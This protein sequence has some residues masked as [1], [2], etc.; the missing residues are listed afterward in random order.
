VKHFGVTFHEPTDGKLYA[1]GCKAVVRAQCGAQGALSMDGRGVTCRLCRDY[2]RRAR[3]L[4]RDAH[5]MSARYMAFS[6]Q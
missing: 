5:A 6:K 4:R 2:L 1:N 3:A